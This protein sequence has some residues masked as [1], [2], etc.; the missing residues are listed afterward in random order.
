[1]KLALVISTVGFLGIHA[2]PGEMQDGR[3]FTGDLAG[4]NEFGTERH[5]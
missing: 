3:Q 4:K 5:A 2:Y 1:M